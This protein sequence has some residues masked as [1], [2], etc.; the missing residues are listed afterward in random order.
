MNAR[1]CSA[2]VLLL[3][4]TVAE[5]QSTA[6][7]AEFVCTEVI[8]VSVT[9]DWFGAGFEDGIDGSRWQARWREHAFAEQWAGPESDLWRMKP[10]SP[11]STRSDRPD[12]VVFTGVNWQWKTRSEWEEKLN[13][14]VQT[15]RARYAG[16]RR[17]ELLTMLR[18]PGNKSCGSEMTVVQPYVDEAVAAVAA[19]FPGLVAVGP[20]VETPDCG[21]FTRGGPHF[22]PEGMARV[23]RLYREALRAR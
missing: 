16:V 10:Q 23:A 6:S 2:T 1:A 18:G 7:G 11:C 22:T 15:I 17:I 9:G 8:G 19:R 3:I 4:A 12:R 20:K 13:A 14:V 5:A 21:V